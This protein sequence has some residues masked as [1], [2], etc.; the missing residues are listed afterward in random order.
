MLNGL[1]PG[2]PLGFVPGGD[3]NV[4]ARALGVPRDPAAAASAVAAGAR[5][6]SLGRVN[7]RRFSFSAGIGFDAEAVRELETLSAPATAGGAGDLVLR[8]RR[9]S[10]P[11]R[12]R[13][14][15]RLEVEGFGRAAFDLRLEPRSSPMPGRGPFRVS[16]EAR[17]ELGLDFVA[18][19]RSGAR[20]RSRLFGRAVGRPRPW[21]DTA[22]VLHGHDL[23]RIDVR[24]DAPLPLQADG[25]DLGD[26]DRGGL[27]GRAR[28]GRRAGRLSVGTI[29]RG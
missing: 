18:P 10:S 20:E 9:D 1:P 4:L 27:R 14:E 21:P 8:A 28:R 5:R 25:E 3:T 11:G 16:P 15:P 26:V 19:E 29:A 6:I 22:G 2:K 13:Y 12:G 23:D 17:F 24:C 7:G